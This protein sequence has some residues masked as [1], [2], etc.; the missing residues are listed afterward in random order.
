MRCAGRGKNDLH[1]DFIQAIERQRISFCLYQY[2][3]AVHRLVH[4]LVVIFP[5]MIG[6][7]GGEH[8]HEFR[9]S[10][11][12]SGNARKSNLCTLMLL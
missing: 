4:A 3:L 5:K 1:Q 7:M 11:V 2:L 10:A 6:C 12:G 8:R 9:E